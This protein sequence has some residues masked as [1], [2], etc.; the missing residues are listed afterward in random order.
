[1]ILPERI[2][3]IPGDSLCSDIYSVLHEYGHFWLVF[4]WN[5]F[6]RHF[7]LFFK[8]IYLFWERDCVWV[9]ER[10]RDRESKQALCWQQTA[11]CG[12]KPINHEI[13]T[14]PKVRCWTKWATQAPHHHLTLKLSLPLYLKWV[15]CSQYTVGYHFFCPIWWSLTFNWGV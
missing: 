15:S 9:A 5:I 8:F 1:M 3:F 12:L 2:L 7:T 4:L 6:F 13:M 14:W 11:Q 10:E